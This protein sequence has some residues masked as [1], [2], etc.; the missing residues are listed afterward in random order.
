MAIFAIGDVQGCFSELV[1]LVE[2]LDFSPQRDQLW[3]TGDLV[4]RG[5]QSL[6]VLRFVVKL[7]TSAKVVLGN[8]DLHLLA[9]ADGACKEKPSDTLSSILRASDSKI[10]LDWLRHQP[11]MVGDSSLKLCMVHAGVYPWWDLQTAFERASEVERVLQSTRHHKFFSILYGN[12]PIRWE[13]HLQ[14]WDRLRFITNS[15]TRMRYCDN[16]RNLLLNQKNTPGNQPP[17]TRPW[18]EFEPV[19]FDDTLTTIVFGHWSALGLYHKDNVLGLDTGCIWGGALTAA[20][21]DPGPIRFF[22]VPSKQKV[23]F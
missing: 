19:N 12:K 17:N 11:L 3:F 18:F 20:Q 7:G 5:P 10:L 6:E 23:R 9:L 21:I 8:H 2:I 4:N 15:F 14:K 13:E 22:S 16:S 1:E